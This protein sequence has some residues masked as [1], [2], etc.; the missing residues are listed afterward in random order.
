MALD[1]DFCKVGVSEKC[2][3]FYFEDKTV[4][5][6]V[7]G[8]NRVDKAHY[9]VGYD[10]VTEGEDVVI[11]GINNDDPVNTINWEIP[12][13]RDGYSYFD[14][15]IVSVWIDT[16][17]FISGDLTFENNKYWIA[18]L[19]NNNQRPTDTEG[20]YWQEVPSAT[21]VDYRD[22]L[23][24][25]GSPALEVVRTDI[26]NLCRSHVCYGEVVTNAAENCCDDCQEQN[27]KDYIRV[28][29]LL[30]S[31]TLLTAQTKYVEAHK[32]TRLLSD[33][34]NDLSD[35]GCS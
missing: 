4:Y 2:D 34:C 3:L 16:F 21:L 26:I 35:C 22:A 32:V 9:L 15:L 13:T 17:P 8:E 31:A 27:N 25:N 5:N 6:N 7:V 10:Y 19:D 11:E 12:S 29:V 24:D 23:N 30:Q 14:V 18:L 20:L 33:V 28:D 1:Y